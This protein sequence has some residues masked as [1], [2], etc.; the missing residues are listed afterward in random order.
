MR[1]CNPGYQEILLLDLNLVVSLKKWHKMVLI[2]IIC[3][4]LITLIVVGLQNIN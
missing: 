3:I 1:L 4:S 2:C